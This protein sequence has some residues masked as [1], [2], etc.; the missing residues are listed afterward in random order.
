M[1]HLCVLVWTWCPHG[2]PE[3]VNVC[4]FSLTY[5]SGVPVSK[6]ITGRNRFATSKES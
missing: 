5:P 6:A 1:V 3:L 4:D 2:G